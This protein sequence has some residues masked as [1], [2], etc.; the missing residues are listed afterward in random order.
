MRWIGRG[1]KSL[2]KFCTVLNMPCPMSHT[3]YR[4]H[5]KVLH[6]SSKT[7]AEASMARAAGEL[8]DEIGSE[9]AVSY[10]GTWMRCGFASL[11]GALIAI[12]WDSGK[13]MDYEVLS[14]YCHECVTL[15]NKLRSGVINQDQYDE[16]CCSHLPCQHNVFCSSHGVCSCQEFWQRSQEHRQL[17]YTTFIGDGD[18][19]TIST[20][21]AAAP[22]GPDVKITKK[23][24][25]GHAQK[26]VGNHLRRLKKEYRGQKL[27]DGL[28]LGG[29]GRLTD[30]LVDKL[31]AY[32]GMAVRGHPDDLQGMARATWAS[33]MHCVS[34]NTNPRHQFCP[35]GLG[36]WCKYQRQQAGV[37]KYTHHECIPEA[38]FKLIKPIFIRLADR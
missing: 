17:R 8:K 36:S 3:S 37:P 38:V 9:I 19:K 23:E 10:D 14:R 22:N 5:V 15:T 31:Q 21:H 25:V 20:R 28:G 35:L 29:Q 2:E 4:R 30:R 13:I 16:S 24:C 1:Q 27:E 34:T 18:A 6:E 33:L 7:V 32:H 12:S 11:Y 26:R